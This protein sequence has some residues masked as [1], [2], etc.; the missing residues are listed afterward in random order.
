MAELPDTKSF[1]YM[2]HSANMRQMLNRKEPIDFQR[3]LIVRQP[4]ADFIVEGQ[5]TLEMR[6]RHTKIRERVGIIPK[7]SG[8]ITERSLSKTMHNEHIY[9]Y[10]R[11]LGWLAE[12]NGRPMRAFFMRDFARQEREE[13]NGFST[14]NKCSMN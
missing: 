1:D 3:A 4:Y 8:L 9:K 10:Y 14:A 5:K 2:I 12:R 7:G 6:S 11:W 13:Q